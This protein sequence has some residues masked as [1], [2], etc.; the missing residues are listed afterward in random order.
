MKKSREVR[1]WDES[2]LED[3]HCGC[4]VG[5]GNKLAERGRCYYGLGLWAEC[6]HLQLEFSPFLER[7]AAL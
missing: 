7:S 2:A 6:L 4:G 1:S 3:P 5:F